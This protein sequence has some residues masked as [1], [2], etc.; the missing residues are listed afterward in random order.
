MRLPLVSRTAFDLLLDERDRLRAKNDELVD[1]LMR[2]DRVRHGM[3]EVPRDSRPAD[4][5]ES[6]PD[7]IR[8]MYE[9]F[10]S[11]AH[12]SEISRQVRQMRSCG[13]PWPEIG[14]ALEVQ[15]G[16]EVEA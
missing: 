15:L 12:R 2:V 9:G 1:G 13:T 3:K 10:Q 11:A 6:I 5:L 14:R 16:E 4:K 7:D 8:A